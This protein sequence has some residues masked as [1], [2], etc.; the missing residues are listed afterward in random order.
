MEHST[1]TS[2]LHF[3]SVISTLYL[4][5]IKHVNVVVEVYFV[6]HRG[7]TSEEGGESLDNPQI[8]NFLKAS[9]NIYKF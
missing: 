2:D 9:L 4:F 5:S 1:K 7:G 8:P 6:V 3:K